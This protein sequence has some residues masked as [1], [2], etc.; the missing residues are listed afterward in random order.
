MNGG[1][2]LKENSKRNA[3]KGDRRDERERVSERKTE[4]SR[5]I[6]E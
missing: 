4:G 1:H 5:E 3:T 2:E 6:E